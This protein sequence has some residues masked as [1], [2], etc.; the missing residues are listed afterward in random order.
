MA[1][2]TFSVRN[3]QARPGL[4]RILPNFETLISRLVF[5]LFEICKMIKYSTDSW[6]SDSEVKPVIESLPVIVIVIYKR[7]VLPRVIALLHHGL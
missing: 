5:K 2:F 1:S 3:G 7:R 4:G 6:L